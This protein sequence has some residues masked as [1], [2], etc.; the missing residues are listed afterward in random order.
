MV[1]PY[2][3]YGSYASYFTAKSRAMLRKK[4][5]PFVER[6]P[7]SAR[8]REYVRPASGS[9]RIPQLEAPDGTVVQDSVQIFDYLEARHPEIPALPPTPR[10]RLVAHLLE[11][12]GSEGLLR[13]AWQFRWFYPEV[14]DRFV[15]MDF[16][17]SF[18]PQ[19]SD[20]EL[21]HYGNVIA[22]R[23]LSRGTLDMS[24][25]VRATMEHDYIALLGCLETHFTSHPY[26]LG[27]HPSVGDYAL[28]GALHAHMG[29]DPKP[30]SI[31]Q[32]NAPRVFRWME[33]M[34]VPDLVAPEF[35]E[36]AVAYPA[37]DE[38]PETVV[39][40]VRH[41]LSAYG[42]QFHDN[43]LAF[44]RYLKTADASGPGAVISDEDQPLL[45]PVT[46]P[47]ASGSGDV[48]C[49]VH[50]VWVTQRPLDWYARMPQSDRD[51]CAALFDGCG[52]EELLGVT[53]DRRVERSD[54]RLRLA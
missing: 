26:V 31:M 42:R 21:L 9:H 39:A 25:E 52:G 11:L 48:R 23:M 20:D 8:F 50:H 27:G 3:L 29:R 4:G 15:K 40:L 43:V 53:I 24:D 16:G 17:R 28:M 45:P 41:L 2:V 33:H 18:R 36:R 34:L 44:N 5:I 32:A 51:F 7:S 6:L 54:N 49:N 14:N 46:I 10:Q 12:L 35:A 22:D 1:E 30:L 38:L 19:G 47:T 37:D 13:I